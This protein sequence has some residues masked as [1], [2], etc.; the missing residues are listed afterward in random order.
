MRGSIRPRQTYG[1]QNLEVPTAMG[2]TRKILKLGDM[3][4][5]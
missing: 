4:G 1:S 5:N 3:K 2:S